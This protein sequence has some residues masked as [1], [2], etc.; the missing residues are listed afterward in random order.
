MTG[1]LVMAKSRAALKKTSTTGSFNL[2]ISFEACM[3]SAISTSGKNCLHSRRLAQVASRYYGDG[4]Q[5]TVLK[6]YNFL[7]KD[8]LEKAEPIGQAKASLK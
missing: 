2:A 6:R 3:P 4:K 5:A 1:S 7:D 8:R